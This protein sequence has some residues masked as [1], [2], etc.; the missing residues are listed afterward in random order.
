[1]WTSKVS[2]N[3]VLILIPAYNEEKNIKLSVTKLIEQ[4]KYDYLIIDDGSIDKTFDVCLKN[5]Y[6]VI[7]HNQNKGLSQAIRTGMNYAWERGYKYVAQY[8]ADGQH[9][10][11]DLVKMVEYIK[12]HKLDILCGNRF[13]KNKIYGHKNPFKEVVRKIFVYFFWK[14]TK[15]QINDPTNG[16]RIFGKNFINQY[17][18]FSKYEVEP[19]TIAYSVGNKKLKIDEFQVTVNK[20]KY[21]KS[22]FSNFFKIIKYV[23]KQFVIYAVASK[24]WKY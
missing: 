9:N 17:Y 10:A 1:M 14:K 3:S 23:V 20:R 2:E 16:L 4:C 13:D 8:D 21:G 6:H 22:K 24:R 12:K 5:G 18:A 11:N 15:I 7:R 19:A